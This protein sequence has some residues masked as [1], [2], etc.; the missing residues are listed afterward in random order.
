MIVD[1]TDFRRETIRLW[2]QV[3]RLEAVNTELLEALQA[4]M[5]ENPNSTEICGWNDD[6][7]HPLNA[8]GV[9]RQKAYKAIAK[10]LGE[11]DNHD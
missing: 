1:Y 8:Y 3:Q 4:V 9:A 7:G 2:Q 11:E 6:D 10:A 5:K